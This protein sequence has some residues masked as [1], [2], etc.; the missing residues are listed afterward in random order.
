MAMLNELLRDLGLDAELLTLARNL[1]DVV[2]TLPPAPD[3]AQVRAVIDVLA[4]TGVRAADLADTLQDA[5]TD[6]KRE[7]EAHARI[8]RADLFAAHI[9]DHH[10]AH[11]A[12]YPVEPPPYPLDRWY[13]CGN[14]SCPECRRRGVIPG[15]I[16]EG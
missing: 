7:Q 14:L 11:V 15:E 6:E 8:E 3:E 5:L 16:D 9:H 2:Q 4:E 12:W 10:G 13:W 1:N